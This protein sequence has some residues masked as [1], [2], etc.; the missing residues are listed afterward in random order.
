MQLHTDERV[1]YVAGGK[2]KVI[3]SPHVFSFSIDA[4][5][6]ARFVHVPIQKGAMLDLCSGNGIIPLILSERSKA[7]IIGVEIQERLYD[8]A[9]RNA[10][11]NKKTEQISF[12]HSDLNALPNSIKGITYDVVTCNPPYFE[13]VTEK[14]KNQN[15]HLAIARHEMYCTLEDVI[16]V[17]SQ[18]VK[19]KG[20]VALVHRPERLASMMTLMRHYK[21]EPKRVQFIHPKQGKDANIV[22]LEGIKASKPGLICLPP[23]MVYNN[24]GVYTEEFRKVYE[25]R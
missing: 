22:L 10:L 15:L 17:S 14:E 13:T 6:L 9:E 12:V 7:S 3:Q 8:M 23:L 2:L 18:L 21:I 1:D 24:E 11:L 4:V 16:R 19:D 20:K 25:G 5:L